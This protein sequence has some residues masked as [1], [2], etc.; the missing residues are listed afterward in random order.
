MGKIIPQLFNLG[1][2]GK[3]CDI[4]TSQSARL[5]LSDE[6]ICVCSG[7]RFR[8]VHRTHTHS[9]NTLHMFTPHSQVDLRNKYR[10]KIIQFYFSTFIIDIEQ[11]FYIQA[12]QNKYLP[13]GKSP[14]CWFGNNTNVKI[15]KI[16]IFYVPNSFSSSDNRRYF[17]YVSVS[18]NIQNKTFCG[19]LNLT[20]QNHFM[21]DTVK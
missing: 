4:P 21:S 11:E 10:D 3:N 13:I 14:L 7:D 15:N 9:G 6:W 20:S 19:R 16:I 12:P 5:G 18:T 1:D 17:N 2:S 8:P